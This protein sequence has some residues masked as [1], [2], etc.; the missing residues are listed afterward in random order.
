MQPQ[1]LE[2]KRERF[3]LLEDDLYIL[4]GNWPKNHDLSV[5]VDKTELEATMEEWESTSALERFS[6][7]EMLQGEKKTVKVRLPENLASYKRFYVYAVAGDEKITWYET[8]VKNLQK[9]QRKPQK[10]P[11]GSPIISLFDPYIFFSWG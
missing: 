7:S 6:E 5:F 11:L 3:H 9:K 4:Q 2:V 1:L 10:K 8:G